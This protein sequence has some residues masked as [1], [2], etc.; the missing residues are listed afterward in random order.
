MKLI[1]IV[2][3]IALVCRLIPT[4][5]DFVFA[6]AFGAYSY[7]ECKVQR[8]E[9]RFSPTCLALSIS[10]PFQSNSR[11]L[12]TFCTMTLSN[13]NAISSFPENLR[14]PFSPMGEFFNHAKFN[15]STAF[16]KRNLI[17]SDGII[18]LL[19]MDQTT[20]KRTKP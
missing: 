5:C 19:L 15:E 20:A 8:H 16:F 12:N 1:H 18:L 14:I 13:D 3:I 11:K 2:V 7:K 6:Y 17:L 9:H 4:G 10:N